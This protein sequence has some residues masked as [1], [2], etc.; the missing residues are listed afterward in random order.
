M[1]RIDEGSAMTTEMLSKMSNESLVEHLLAYK[2]RYETLSEEFDEYKSSSMEMEQMLEKE[3]QEAE[4]ARRTAESERDGVKRELER[5][6][7][8]ADADKRESCAIEE[9]LRVELAAARSALDA[10]RARIRTLEQANDDLERRDRNQEQMLEDLS[11]NL[12]STI[13]RAALLESELAEIHYQTE[14]ASRTREELR[15]ERPRVAVEPLRME[16]IEHTPEDTPEEERKAFAAMHIDD[17]MEVDEAHP[18][19]SM[20]CMQHVQQVQPM[21]LPPS[22]VSQGEGECAASGTAVE[23]EGK[24]RR[25]F[26]HSINKIVKELLVRVD[27]VENILTTLKSGGSTPAPR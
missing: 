18:S 19:T 7:I 13:E 4:K 11:K 25:P 12:E 10:A 23:E 9:R 17:R 27:R 2:D 15:S 5:V 22:P 26:T 3:L 24:T 16:R 14:S 1:T 6:T 8:R 21:Q 20:E